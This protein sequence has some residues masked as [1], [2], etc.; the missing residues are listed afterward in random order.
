MIDKSVYDKLITYQDILTDKFRLEEQM[1]DL[2]KI[3]A[4]KN[5][6][7]LRAKKSY[8]TKHKRFKQLEENVHSLEKKINE[9]RLEKSEYEEKINLVK[10]QKEYEAIDRT[11]KTNKEREDEISIQIMQDRR[12]TDDL[13][14]DI[15]DYELNLKQQEEEI[16]KEQDRINIELDKIKKE[17]DVIK[18]KEAE[19]VPEIGDDFRY[20]FEKIVKNKEGKGIVAI[21]GGYCTG[22]FLVL[23]PEY[24]NKVRSNDKIYFCPNC[25]RTLYFDESPDNIFT[26]NDEEMDDS[27]FFSFDE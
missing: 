14:S 2:P 10:T 8:L 20:K 25:S 1:D 11:L 19:I 9:L 22:C 24:I 6:V 17:L 3:I 15:E 18:K 27:D 12:M 4:S 23:P 13:R 21:T 5:E 26:I 7:L 16:S